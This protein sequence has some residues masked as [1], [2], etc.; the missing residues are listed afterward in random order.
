[1]KRLVILLFLLTLTLFSAPSVQ[2]AAPETTWPGQVSDWF[3]YEAH[4]FQFDGRAAESRAPSRESSRFSVDL[5]RALL[6][7]RT[8]I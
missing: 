3:G 1:M 6:R 4:D 2:G 7:T 8:P 5:A